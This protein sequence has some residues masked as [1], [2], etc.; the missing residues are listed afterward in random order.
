WPATGHARRW[1][2][3][4][5]WAHSGSASWQRACRWGA[6]VGGQAGLG[7]QLSPTTPWLTERHGYDPTLARHGAR[8]TLVAGL[9]LGALGLGLLAACLP[10]GRGFLALLPAIVILSV[11]QGMTW[12][13]MW[14]SAAS[15]VDPP[16]Q[17]VASG[18]ASMTQQIGGA[19]GLALLVALANAQV[20][21]AD[22]ASLLA[23]QARGIEWVTA[24]SALL[25]L[26]GAALALRLRREEP[27]ALQPSRG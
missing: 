5:C 19:L 4:C 18:M 1:S 22:A 11:G 2:P 17:G 3:A 8:A 9:L 14:V 26:C 24:L 16:E 7:R 23:S 21:G 20:R 25:A 13:A 15:G 27:A 12:T 6:E 10:L